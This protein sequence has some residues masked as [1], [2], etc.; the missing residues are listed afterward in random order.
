MEQTRMFPKEKLHVL[1]NSFMG[2]AHV[3]G[4]FAGIYYLMPKNFQWQFWVFV[5]VMFASRAIGIT[6]GYHRYFTHRSFKCGKVMQA[7]LA[8]FGN[9]A[10]EGPVISW[11]ADHVR[12]HENTDKEGDPYNAARGFWHS[13][14]GWIL[15]KDPDRK[16][17]YS[18]ANH[19]RED[20]FTWAL[21]N[22]QRKYYY[23]LAISLDAVLPMVIAWFLWGNPLAGLI[24]S[25]IATV[26]AWHAT[27][28]INSLAHWK[29]WGST[30]PYSRENTS[31]DSWI[32]SLFTFGEGYHNYH[33]KFQRD[34]RNGPLW[35]NFDPSK[36]I[37][38]WLSN[39]GLAWDL[40]RVPD[41]KIE[42]A[43]DAVREMG[44]RS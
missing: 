12:H 40:V 14:I 13:H 6:V 8:M 17:D 5:L 26:L 32:V 24:A 20:P 41:W 36:W 29:H 4:V 22:F 44:Y 30:Q 3:I 35:Y 10:I 37:I 19:L 15:F 2:P 25:F 23:A 39:L 21:V 31:Q 27:F 7:L 28:C 1:N 43:R 18:A 11:V 33:H 9:G 38:F 42:A 34:Y 16:E